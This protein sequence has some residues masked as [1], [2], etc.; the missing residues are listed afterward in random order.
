[1]TKTSANAPP[2]GGAPPVLTDAETLLRA[3]SFH[4]RLERARAQRAEALARLENGEA[5]R[6]ARPGAGE[7]PQRPG[8]PDGFI[9]NPS[10]PFDST[11]GDGLPVRKLYAHEAGTA[12][13]RTEPDRPAPDRPAPV[14]PPTVS[15]GERAGPR[16]PTARPAFIGHAE[17]DARLAAEAATEPKAEAVAAAVPLSVPLPAPPAAPPAAPPKPQLVLVPTAPVAKPAETFVQPPAIVP[18]VSVPTPAATLLPLSVAALDSLDQAAARALAQSATTSPGTAKGGARGLASAA[19]IAA[20]ALAGGVWFTQLPGPVESDQAAPLAAAPAVP[21]D[22][23][24]GK[25]PVLA[26]AAPAPLALAPTA[27]AQVGA[28]GVAPEAPPG[29]TP[30]QT[31]PRPLAYPPVTLANVAAP[32]TADLAFAAPV[33][34]GLA[35]V[36][37]PV[38]PAPI[39]APQ[40][41]LSQPHLLSASVPPSVSVVPPARASAAPAM[42]DVPPMIPPELIVRL[43]APKGTA[44]ADR[45]N[46]LNLLTAAGVAVGPTEQADASEIGPELRYFHPAD[47][48]AANLLAAHLGLPPGAVRLLAGAT[49]QAGSFDLV[50][51]R[52]VPPETA[53]AKPASAKPAKIP[54]GQ[55]K[56]RA[57][58]AG[59]AA[60]MEALKTKI[61]QQLQGTN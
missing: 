37:A 60:A 20:L 43:L 46:F 32:A 59:D 33:V 24:V 9:L 36:A 56:K 49:Q 8:G 11:D 52:P 26:A 51:A 48:V 34:G 31:D 2:P 7:R 21:V 25:A 16:G 15:R 53:R 50:V 1:M 57:K 13:P 22:A 18:E 3:G 4:A 41:G 47:Q 23:P 58:K 35:P 19:A 28:P 14:A 42:S 6:T 30:A 38:A 29:A 10:R 17:E 12:R 45:Q 27:D 44:K 40:P 5:P 39:T 55:A 54:P 61:L